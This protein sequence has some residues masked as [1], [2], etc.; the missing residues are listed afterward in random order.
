M[1][2]PRR[3][4]WRTSRSGLRIS[5]APHLIV[6]LA[7]IKEVAAQ[8]NMDLVAGANRRN[9]QKARSRLHTNV[10]HDFRNTARV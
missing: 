2:W 5:D 8:A 6:A 7:A 3:A 4:P 9:E 10:R 1:A